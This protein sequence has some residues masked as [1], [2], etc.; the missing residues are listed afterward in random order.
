MK[1]NSEGNLDA[2]AKQTLSNWRRVARLLLQPLVVATGSAA[3]LLAGFRCLAVDPPVLTIAPMGSNQFSVTITNGDAT[4]NYELY[5]AP[6]LANPS[7]PFSLLI[8]GTQ[9]Q[10]N[11]SIDAGAWQSL[12][13][14]ASVGIDWDADGVPNYMDANP[15]DAL[16][17][18]LTVTIDSP[19]NG[20][21]LN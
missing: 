17:G 12:Y 3:I 21:E 10:T 15:N 1:S 6:V 4:A 8:V 7:Y 18:A 9:G 20:S 5:W 14:R 16:I 2:K 19:I 11:F 13:F